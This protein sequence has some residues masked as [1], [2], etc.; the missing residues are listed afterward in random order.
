LSTELIDRAR[1]G[2]ETAF[3]ELVGPYQA[4]VLQAMFSGELLRAER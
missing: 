2:D 4:A 3:Q 1:S